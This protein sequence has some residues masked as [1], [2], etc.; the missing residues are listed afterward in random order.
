MDSLWVILV[1]SLAAI[2]CSLLGTYLMLRKMAMVSDAMAHSVLPGIV[3]AFLI[4]SSKSSFVV[5]IGAGFIGVLSTFLIGFLHTK[6]KLQSDASI[7]VNFTWMFALGIILVSLYSKKIDLDPECVLY[8]EIAYVPLDSWITNAGMNLGPKPMY[9]LLL[10]LLLNLIFIIV[11]YKKL[12][13]T[14]FDPLY[15]TSIGININIWHYL[16]MGITSFTI[17]IVFDI[18]GV[19]LT[20]ALIIVPPAT[21]YLITKNLKLMLLI[22]VILGTFDSVVG[23]FLSVCI[24]SAISGAMVTVAG[25]VFACV[26]GVHCIRRRYGTF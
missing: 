4:T 23:Y 12:M 14:T 18:V 25:C 26:F 3:I 8:G 13:I 1:G 6:A 17:V 21:A 2:N 10:V 15:S 16:L 7:G 5:I 9:T 22:S 11:S 20:V 19:V 24:N